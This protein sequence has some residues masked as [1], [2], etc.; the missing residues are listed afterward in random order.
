MYFC[1]GSILLPLAPKC[2]ELPE[3]R[4]FCSPWKRKH[5]EPNPACTSPS[6]EWLSRVCAPNTHTHQQKHTKL[7]W[8]KAIQIMWLWPQ[9][10]TMKEEVEQNIFPYVFCSLMLLFCRALVYFFLFKFFFLFL[11]ILLKWFIW[12]IVFARSQ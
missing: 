4:C 1:D 8:T 2:W 6:H 10:P 3:N 11:C 9:D 7:P 12:P 5:W